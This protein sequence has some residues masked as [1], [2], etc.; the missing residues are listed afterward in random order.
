MASLQETVSGYLDSWVL[1]DEHAQPPLP[2]VEVGQFD[3]AFVVLKT[4][5]AHLLDR[6]GLPVV[7]GAAKPQQPLLGDE[8]AGIEINTADG[9]CHVA[10]KLVQYARMRLVKPQ[11]FAGIAPT[12]MTIEMIE[13][14]LLRVLEQK[15]ATMRNNNQNLNPVIV[16]SMKRG[17]P[18]L[19]R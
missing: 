19:K 9:T 2:A 7:S 5:V 4:G 3:Q 17:L 6:A 16:E 10:S 14:D 15:Q 1:H 11:G 18:P 13:S 12:R 8:R